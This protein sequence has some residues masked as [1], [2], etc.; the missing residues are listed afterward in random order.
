MWSQGFLSHERNIRGLEMGVG[1]RKLIATGTSQ[2]R[3][4]QNAI[5]FR[6]DVFTKSKFPVSKTSY[7]AEL[8][9]SLSTSP[10]ANI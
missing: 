10:L 4:L 5:M 6:E 7:T 3:I 1:E 9:I 2:G 8:I